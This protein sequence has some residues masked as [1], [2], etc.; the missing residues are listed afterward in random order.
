[1]TVRGEG[2]MSAIG[3]KIAESGLKSILIICHPDVFLKILYY[4]W[5]FYYN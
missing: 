1:M 4:S 2:R 3:Q 5:N